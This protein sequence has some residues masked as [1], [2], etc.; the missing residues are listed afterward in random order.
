MHEL[1]LVMGMA[2]IIKEQM[3][4]HSLQKLYLV[5]VKYGSLSSLEPEAFRTAFEA[6]SLE[7]ELFNGVTLKLEEVPLAL[8]CESCGLEF[9]PEKVNHPFT[10]CPDCGGEEGHRVLAGR[11]I[12]ID[13]IEAE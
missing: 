2:D 8:R 13:Y 12:Y 3:S 1:S 11:D 9:T 5:A 6:V 7:Q 4:E 10:P